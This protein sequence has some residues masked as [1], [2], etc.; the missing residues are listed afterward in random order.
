M[1]KH[2]TALLVLG[3]L[4]LAAQMGRGTILGTVTDPTGAAVPR[5]SVTVTNVATNIAYHTVTNGDGYYTTPGMVVGSYSVSVQ[6]NGFK[7]FLRTGIQLEV[8]QKIVIDAALQVGNVSQSVE[9][10]GAAPLVDVASA[11]MG[12][13][14][15]NQRIQNLPLNGRNVLNLTLLSP[16]IRSN[17]NPTGSGIGERGFDVANI[18]VNGGQ[19]GYNQFTIDGG[20][21]NN[22]VQDE[23]NVN[24]APDSVQEFKVQSVAVSAEYGFTLGGTVNVATK[25]GTN[26]LHGTLYDYLGNDAFNARN[27][28]AAT[29]TPERYNQF[30]GSLGG[31]VWIPKIYNG[32]NRTFFYY[33]YEGYRYSYWGY[34]YATVPTVAE[35]GGDFSQYEDAKGNLIP[36]YDPATTAINPNGSGYIRQPFPGNII[37]SSRFDKIT[38]K[39]LNFVAQPN[40]A[41]TNIYQQTN[42]YYYQSSGGADSHQHMARLDQKFSDNN[43]F[44]ARYMTFA[45]YPVAS[46]G[47]VVPWSISGRADLYKDQNLVVSDTNI[48]SPSVVNDFRL[49]LARQYFTYQSPTVGQNWPQRLGMP[50]G[51]TNILPTM[52]LPG[53]SIG[54]GFVGNYRA[55]LVSGLFDAVTLIRGNHSIKVGTEIRR[56]L[57]PTG[58]TVPA[59]AGNWSFDGGLTNNPQSPTG[60]GAGLAQFLLGAVSSGSI[61]S[62]GDT[63]LLNY[64]A[65]FFVQDDWRVSRR[66]TLNLGLRDDF[67]QGAYETHDR[68]SNFN[69][70]V[71]NPQTNLP[72]LTQYADQG[73]FPS[74]LS[75]GP[76]LSPRIGLA[77]D[78]RGDGKTALR[79]AYSIFYA[80]VHNIV[81]SSNGYGAYSTNYLPPNSNG[82][83][84]AF[85]FDQGLPYPWIAPLGNQMGPNIN[86]VGGANFVQSNQ[87]EPMSQQWEVSLQHQL[88]GNW[89]VEAAYTGNHGT[90]LEASGYNLNQ[91]NPMYDTQYKMALQ[92]QVPNPY[93]GI[94]PGVLGGKTVPQ[95]QLLLPY[96]WV[97]GITVGNPSVLMGNSIY[98]AFVLS[99]QKRMSHGLTAQVSYTF[100]KMISDS[101]YSN[102]DYSSA[103]SEGG[104]YQNGLYDRAAE[105]SVDP[106]DVTH[107]LVVSVV[108]DL[109]FGTGKRFN[110]N[111]RVLNGILGGWQF[112]TITTAQSGLPLRVTGASNFLANRPNSTG[113]S[114]TLS[115]HNA[116][117]WLNPAAFINPPDWTFGNVG[118]TLPQTWGPGLINS[119]ASLIKDT[120]IREQATLEFRAEF[121]NSLNHVNLGMP[122]TSFQAGPDGTNVNANFGKI[123]SARSARSG[124]LALKVIF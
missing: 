58:A 13:V 93:A 19:G 83:Y 14:V 30:G 5:A 47:G 78:V 96:P 71:T 111:N 118:R 6:A 81:Y 67:Q 50:S 41:P 75:G 29:L 49:S 33:N 42:N 15:E 32:K 63:T 104:G 103:Q 43:M 120:R 25:S 97:Q 109:P 18:S 110:F 72:G 17:G 35:R 107:R 11:T 113:I 91:L 27:A 124:Q 92:N 51:F 38:P 45:Q 48:F 2:I 77:W 98:D 60:T 70:Y 87:H 55:G 73:S 65:S 95:S 34:N 89:M 102:I 85:Y 121:F 62:Y 9:V 24:P 94:L 10:S 59:N 39:F 100:S 80:D 117:L 54:P 4:P 44:Y 66:L 64:S 119:D 12:N 68:L 74:I 36:I 16:N 31:P 123:L 86:L 88:P 53:L 7:E 26:D 56:N 21:A 3:S 52:N 46:I 84:P 99:V 40:A 82:N 37:P 115:N 1:L 90:H 112:T 69:P 28:F 20:V 108:Y 116:N 57:M 114:P 105:R 101:L 22:A 23:V 61:T 106:L 122:I 76:E 79:A 8:D